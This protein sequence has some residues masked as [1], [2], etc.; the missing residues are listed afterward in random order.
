MEAVCPGAWL[1]NYTNPMSV[2]CRAVN[3]TTGIRTVGLCHELYGCL[4]MLREIFGVDSNDRL[5]YRV[6]GINHLIFLV[7]LRVDGR[8]GF[9]LLRD[10]LREHPDYRREPVPPESPHY[11]FNDRALLKLELFD[12]L[13]VLPAAGDRHIAEF[14][15]HYLT[16]ETDRGRRYGIELTTIAHRQA[17]MDEA[18][19]RAARIARG[20]EAIS[21]EPSE[22]A[23]A[24]II[25]ALA[26][27][28]A[29]TDVMNLPNTGQIANLP[30]DAVVETLATITKDRIV[31]DQVGDVPPAVHPLLEH[32]IRVQEMTVEAALTLS[33]IHI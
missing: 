12:E 2:L 21:L 32:H 15:P 22:E 30:R 9:A 6:A 25:D 1:L 8:D 16:D 5:D 10:F 7:E 33:L 27:G 19:K 17:L 23:A 28:T 18:S 11:P 20:D 13:G 14:F 4:R 24:R 29:C 3:K 31:P 26:N